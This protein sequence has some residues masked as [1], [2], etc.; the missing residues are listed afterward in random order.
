MNNG[1]NIRPLKESEDE[2]DQARLRRAGELD[3]IFEGFFEPLDSDITSL[4]DSA[5]DDPPIF[6]PGNTDQPVG[7]LGSLP[8]SQQTVPIFIQLILLILMIIYL[9][10]H[11]RKPQP[12]PSPTRPDAPQP[13]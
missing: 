6:D 10:Y 5:F 1:N 9:N 11:F 4:P 13:G 7:I 2:D 12:E 8:S 3:A